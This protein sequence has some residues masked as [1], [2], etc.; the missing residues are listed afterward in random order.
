MWEL[1]ALQ[2]LTTRCQVRNMHQHEIV[3]R[4][5]LSVA[6]NTT[7]HSTQHSTAAAMQATRDCR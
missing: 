2:E 7:Q 3:P 6:E 1:A 4:L 5:H